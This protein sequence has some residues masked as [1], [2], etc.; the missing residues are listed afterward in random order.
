MPTE[1]DWREI[2]RSFDTDLK[3]RTLVAIRKIA[4]DVSL[5]SSKKVIAID[6]LLTVAGFPSR[7]DDEQS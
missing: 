1:N 2:A 4:D 6:Q 5:P 7:L 3:R